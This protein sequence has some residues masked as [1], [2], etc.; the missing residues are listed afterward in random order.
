MSPILWM[1]L[2]AGALSVL[3][4]AGLAVAEREFRTALGQV[5]VSLAVGPAILV[6]FL[7]RSRAPRTIRLS[8]EALERFSRQQGRTGQRAWAF[9]YR[10]RGVILVRRREGTDWLNDVPNRVARTAREAGR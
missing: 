3:G 10:S 5:L 4:L 9:A 2:G 6:A 7:V 1:L 8:P